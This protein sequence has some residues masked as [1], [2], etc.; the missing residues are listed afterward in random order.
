VGGRRRL[1]LLVHAPVYGEFY[2]SALAVGEQGAFLPLVTA[3]LLFSD[4]RL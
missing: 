4:V 3:Y 2:G 1:T